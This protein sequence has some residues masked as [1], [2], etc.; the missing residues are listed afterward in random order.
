MLI[1]PSVSTNSLNLIGDFL[2]ILTSVLVAIYIVIINLASRSISPVKLIAIS[3][4][5]SAVSLF[6]ITWM[7][8]ES[9]LTYEPEAWG[10][11]IGL[12][13]VCQFIGQGLIAYSL[14]KLSVLFSSATLMIQP[15]VAAILSCYLFL[16]YLSIF[17]VTGI[18]M[19]LV[20]IYISRLSE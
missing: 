16:E 5:S 9:F 1:N 11:L 12:A 10:I 2:G 15:L 7:S 19:T 3:T 6:L 4:L 18:L 17:Q 13:F 20:G 8:G 14:P